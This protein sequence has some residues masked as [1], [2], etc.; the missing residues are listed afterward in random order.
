MNGTFHCKKDFLGML[1]YL[2][3]V[4]S[5]ISKWAQCHHWDLYRKMPSSSESDIPVKWRL[6]WCLWTWRTG[7]VSILSEHLEDG[8]SF[9][10]LTFRKNEVCHLLGFY[11]ESHF[12]AFDL[13]NYILI[14][15]SAWTTNFDPLY[16]SR[17]KLICI[18]KL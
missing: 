4:K 11:S 8:S 2:K 3:I 13:Y 7:D 17:R 18:L 5:Q 16:S 10:F 15:F 1:K 6:G 12:W 9:F 14:Y